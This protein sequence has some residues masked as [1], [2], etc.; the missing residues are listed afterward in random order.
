MNTFKAAGPWERDCFLARARY[1]SKCFNTIRMT[2]VL[3]NECNNP[4]T[5]RPTNGTSITETVIHNFTV[6]IKNYILRVV[7]D[8]KHLLARIC[9]KIDPHAV[10]VNVAT[11]F[12]CHAPSKPQ[13]SIPLSARA[14]IILTSL[15]LYVS[16]VLLLFYSMFSLWVLINY[17]LL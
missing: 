3:G 12:C 17:Y 1:I 4:Q 2:S 11:L 13:L 6:K 7:F 16:C 9:S 5:S 10:A 8:L 15:L 14:H